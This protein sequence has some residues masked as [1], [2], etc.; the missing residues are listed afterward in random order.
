MS[1]KMR[2]QSKWLRPWNKELYVERHCHLVDRWE[3]APLLHWLNRP[4]CHFRYMTFP[5][6]TVWREP[7]CRVDVPPSLHELAANLLA[8]IKTNTVKSW[9][10]CPTQTKRR[11][12]RTGVSLRLALR[13]SW[14][15]LASLRISSEANAASAARRPL[16]GFAGKTCL[17]TL[18]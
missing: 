2:T 18:L 17:V 12:F 9:L 11:T 7:F 8:G 4:W 6:N 10:R 15:Y 1:L 5:G 13:V 16:Q 14:R 3:V